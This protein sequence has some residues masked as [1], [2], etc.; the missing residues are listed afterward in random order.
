MSEVKLNLTDRYRT[1]QGTIHG[2][3]ADAAVA[4]LSAEPETIRELERALERYIKPAENRSPFA[5]FHERRTIDEE[6]WDAGIVVIDLVARIVAAESTYSQP[7]HK[8]RVNYHNGIC[9]TDITVPYRVSDNW[10]FLQSIAEYEGARSDRA[11]HRTAVPELDARAILYGRPLLEFIYHEV[12]QTLVSEDPAETPTSS[13]APGNNASSEEPD[14]PERTES[15]NELPNSGFEEPDERDARIASEIHARWLMTGRED[16][17]NRSPREILLEKQDFIDFDL[18][19]REMQWSLQGE[20]PPGLATDS[21]G[22]RYAGFGTQEWVIYYDLVRDLLRITIDTVR[23]TLLCR[24]SNNISHPMTQRT[25]KLKFVEQV[26]I[27]R[28]EEIKRNWL[29]TPCPEYDNWTPAILIQRERQ[30]LPTTISGRE[31]IIDEDCPIC[32]M[33]ASESESGGEITFWSLDGAHMDDDF[34]FSNFRSREE[35]ELDRLEWQAFSEKFRRDWTDRRDS[36]SALE[37]IGD[38]AF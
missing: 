5:S 1:I 2:S 11:E 16:L 35:W 12:V 18:E 20:A 15:T 30:R 36:R 32:Q 19:I 21:F 3:V 8:G 14:L 31:L 6:P 13:D 23:K 9:A 24:S 38:D 28:L 33:M 34:V 4:A 10:L 29:G 22:Y 37:E 7:S 17:R 26:E 27:D 25:E